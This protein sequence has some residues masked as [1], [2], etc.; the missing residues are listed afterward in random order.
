MSFIAAAL[1]GGGAA[2]VGGY[3]SSQGAAKAGQQASDAANNATATN[4]AMFDTTNRQQAPWRQAGSNALDTIASLQPQFQHQFNASDLNANLAP[5]YQFQLDQGLGAVKNAGNLQTGLIS[6]NTMKG[7]N[8]YAQ[9]Y[10]GNAYQNAFA[11]YNTN[12]TNIFNRLSSIAG[13]GQ[14]A[15]ANVGN[16]GATI[17]GNTGT[18]QIASGASLAAGTMGSANAISGGLNG[19]GGWY[20][21]SQIMNQGGGGT[22]YN[23]GNYMNYLNGQ[24]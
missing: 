9:N 8:D 22:G 23:Q 7:I 11:N 2:L 10:A 13:L 3:I 4:Q 5:N 21:L 17:A 15:N 16:A 20:G 19:A 12:Q 6:G 14:T 1:I 24:N 18:A